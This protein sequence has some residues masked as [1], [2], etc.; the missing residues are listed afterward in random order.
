MDLSRLET[1]ETL[2]AEIRRGIHKNEL[3]R[4]F[5]EE[6]YSIAKAKIKNQRIKKIPQEY[7]FD[8]EDLRFATNEQVADY[9]AKRLKCNIIIE[10]GCGVGIQT[11]A[12][13]KTCKKVIAIEVDEKKIGYAKHNAKTAGVNNIEFLKGDAFKE[14][15]G[16]KA[17][18]IFWDPER[19]PEEKERFLE[20]IKPNF[21]KTLEKANKI[22]DNICV[23]LPPQ[24]EQDKIPE[25]FE[26]EYVSLNNKLNRLNIYS[27]KL[28]QCEI[29]VVSLPSE[30][31]IEYNNE[32]LEKIK[33][34]KKVKDYLYE[35]DKTL[36]ISGL[37]DFFLS[38]NKELEKLEIGKI[39]LTS[40]KEIKNSFLKS[41]K[42]LGTT[43]MDELNSFL[44]KQEAGKITLRGQIPQ[45]RYWQIKN[46]IEAELEGE[47]TLHVFFGEEIIVA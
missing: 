15:E 35:I 16:L 34:I 10:I 38:K 20:S 9:R 22:T 21:K 27:G 1:L 18:I 4:R 24:I 29:S 33:T 42:V 7:L 2:E 25:G 23:E 47:K 26:K 14:L 28:K 37:I 17:D 13:A 19:P 44:K 36:I 30:E 8:E 43:N 45:D 11:I 32:S 46:S 12:F 5:S 41:F 3:I 6:L 31:R 39:Y 40:K